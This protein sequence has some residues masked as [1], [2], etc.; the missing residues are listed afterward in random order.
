MKTPKGSCQIIA[1]NER[2][3]RKARKLSM[4]KFAEISGVSLGSL[5]RFENTGEI[6]LV[7]LLKLAIV[8]DCAEEFEQL[9]VKEHIMSIQEIIDGKV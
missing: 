9:F 1:K 6:S 4:E 8:L 5:K 2:A 3:Q 7:S